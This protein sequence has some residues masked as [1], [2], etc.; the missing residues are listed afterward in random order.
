M[1]LRLELSRGAAL[2]ATARWAFVRGPGLTGFRRWRTPSIVQGEVNLTSQRRDRL[3]PEIH[4]SAGSFR[5]DVR[6]IHR[7]LRDS[8]VYN[9]IVTTLS[10]TLPPSLFAPSSH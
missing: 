5:P 10:S 2:Q 1:S 3:R 8:E 4:D 6:G 7:Y 9:E